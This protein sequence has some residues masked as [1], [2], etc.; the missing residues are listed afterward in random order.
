MRSCRGSTSSNDAVAPTA[1]ELRRLDAAAIAE[2]EPHAR[3]IAGFTRPPRVSST[4]AR[5]REPRAGRARGRRIRRHAL[6]RHRRRPER[7]GAPTH[8]RA[9]VI[10]ADHAVFCAG[11]WADRLAR[12]RGRTDPIRGSCP[13]AAPTFVSSPSG[14]SSCARS[15]TPS[16]TRR[17][18]SS[19]STSH[20]TSGRG[21]D[22][23]D[24]AGRVPAT[25]TAARAH[26]Q[27]LLDTLGLARH[28]ANAATLL[29]DRCRGD[30]RAPRC[31]RPS[32]APPRAC[33]RSPGDR[34][35]TIIRRR[36]RPG[37]G[38]RRPPGRRLRLLRGPSGP[39]TSATR[40]RPPRPPRSPSPGTSPT[41]SRRRWREPPRARTKRRQRTR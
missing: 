37:T 8:P 32:C 36:A 21:A 34:R 24:R 13:S 23:P 12:A 27:D 22:R 6:R 14:A 18:H 26:R 19:A 40:P 33:A 20:G 39:F 1:C 25:A 10:E 28:V 15:S 41:R 35:R 31:A 2:L 29:D 30:L 3:G 16:P 4:S 17:C 11:A 9:R 38:S 5:S 7:P